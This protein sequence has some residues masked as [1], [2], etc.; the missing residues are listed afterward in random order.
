MVRQ[1]DHKALSR[2]PGNNGEIAVERAMVVEAAEVAGTV[3]IDMEG[4]SR[5]TE[6]T[7][8]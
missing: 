5:T 1:Y 6:I 4:P 8:P 7:Q 2:I 3:V